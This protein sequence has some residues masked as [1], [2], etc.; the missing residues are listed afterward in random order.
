MDFNIDRLR[1]FIVVARTGNLS[2]AAKELGASQPNVGRQMTALEKEVRIALFI[3]HSRGLELT[4]EGKDFL[5]LCQD[6]VGRLAQGTD[7]IRE[8]K[9]EPHGT[10][11]VVS[12]IGSSEAILK[13]LH[14]FIE[15]FPKVQFYFTSYTNILDINP[16]QFKIGDTDIAYLPV[17]F[18]DPDLVQSHICDMI[19][20]IYAAPSYLKE[21]P[22]PKT[23]EDIKS[24]RMIILTG[25]NN[26]ILP[27]LNP[28]IKDR[29][30]D[31][32]SQPIIAVNNGINL[33]SALI[34]GLGIGA[35]SY[36]QELIKNNLL[37]DVFPDM[38]DHVVPYY[39]TYHRRLE[40]S[41]KVQAFQKFLKQVAK[42][43]ERPKKN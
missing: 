38:P 18:S 11:K 40:G 26:E 27:S 6:I 31:F 24:H 21:H 36:D 2:A 12:G 9:S 37:I 28:H 4:E 34:E 30:V 17:S 20:R 23:L 22:R 5:G 1:T 42:V 29:E 39:L 35:Y 43:W 16:F 25:E 8:K 32:Y 33:R 14:L 13:N 7:V 3:R 10:L 19:L 41:P 15:K